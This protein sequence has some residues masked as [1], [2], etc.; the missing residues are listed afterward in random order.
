MTINRFCP[1]C[2]A[3]VTYAL[4]QE[5]FDTA[6][7][8][9]LYIGYAQCLQYQP[10]FFL[11]IPLPDLTGHVNGWIG[12]NDF[13]DHHSLADWMEML[14][15]AGITSGYVSV[16]GSPLSNVLRSEL[17]HPK[18]A[19]AWLVNVCRYCQHKLEP[20]GTCSHCGAPANG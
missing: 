14:T 6:T 15:K 8:L 11:G 18:S 4:R 20:D 19:P 10:R 17:D 9:P 16:N 3:L 7:G 2:G 1:D 12:G 13:K 5:R